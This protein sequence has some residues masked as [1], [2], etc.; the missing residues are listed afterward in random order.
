MNVSFELLK[1][2]IS[3]NYTDKEQYEKLKEVVIDYHNK[4]QKEHEDFKTEVLV[5]EVI[6]ECEIIKKFIEVKQYV[7]MLLNETKLLKNSLDTRNFEGFG[8]SSGSKK[9]LTS[10]MNSSK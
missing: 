6:K 2:K 5:T 4:Y 9:F 10:L 1:A 7:E 8:K 3:R